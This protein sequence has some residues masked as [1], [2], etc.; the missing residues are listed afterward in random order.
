[1]SLLLDALKKAAEAKSRG[2]S[3][4]SADDLRISEAPP[5]PPPPPTPEMPHSAPPGRYVEEFD[6]DDTFDGT[7]SDTIG[8]RFSAY[9]EFDETQQLVGDFGERTSDSFGSQKHAETVF[10]SKSVEKP[11]RKRL[12]I[13]RV[14]IVALLL[15]SCS[16]AAYLYLQSR[17]SELR[18]DLSNISARAPI[19]P[20]AEEAVPENAAS[21]E[22]TA[23]VSNTSEATAELASTP[24]ESTA[25][26]GVT[27]AAAADDQIEESTSG[28]G[29][30]N[31]KAVEA[32]VATS[33]QLTT[34]EVDEGIVE[35][36]AEPQ[37]TVQSDAEIGD[38]NTE[39]TTPADSTQADAA[40]ASENDVANSDA[41]LT[42]TQKLDE[43]RADN[44]VRDAYAA[45]QAGQL[46]SA[47]T[48]YDNA[49]RL[50][51]DHRDASLGRAAI[52]LRRN[53]HREAIEIY[54]QLLAKNPRDHDALAGLNSLA[55]D[56]NLVRYESDLR[57]LLRDNPQSAP[58][59]YAL[60]VVLSRQKRWSGAQQ[61]F[62]SAFS[63]DPENPDV[64]FNLAVSLDNLGKA[65]PAAQY[66]RTALDL[67]QTRAAN[68][69][70]A[71]VRRRLAVLEQ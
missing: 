58:L 61:H 57:F 13:G 9:D 55:R 28:Q 31:E 66:Y 51:P 42:I 34:P 52:Y 7:H 3:A 14:V 44:L 5:P 29:A 11:L 4:T 67:A 24:D 65:A 15:V 63:R 19:V 37:Q 45:Y 33:E 38:G 27:E 1:M 69:D 71:T 26:A 49:L 59:N 54:Q 53:Q 36:P 22:L 21:A 62:F 46:E 23:D 30:E 48:L 18:R 60:G 39:E 35:S 25:V 50:E 40:A 56:D 8:H 2:D 12:P 32:E 20:I 41:S 16:G 47:Q 17:D 70:A 6:A 10:T 43:N 68:F 64:A